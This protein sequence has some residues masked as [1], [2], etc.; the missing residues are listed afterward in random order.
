MDPALLAL[1]G[2]FIGLAFAVLIQARARAWVILP[3]ETWADDP[4]IPVWSASE[5]GGSGG[6]PPELTIAEIWLFRPAILRWVRRRGVPKDAAEDVAQL[7][8]D[9]A[10]RNRH[11][12]DR[13][14]ALSTWLWT[15][16]R[17][18]SN[19][20]LRRAHVRREILASEPLDIEAP[21]DPESALDLR[22]KTAEA[23]AILGCLPDHLRL[24]F[25]RYELEGAD[26]RALAI[27]LGWPQST[28]WERLTQARALIAR[29]VLRWRARR[30]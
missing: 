23:S 24:L 16:S 14:C 20:W 18:Q 3:G 22:R 9:G 25:T 17:N 11:S 10:F 28:A 6:P 1:F 19:N 29:E 13:S 12:W 26:M 30:R 4:R 27:E 15:I 21:G 7:V 8:I 5:G 2:A